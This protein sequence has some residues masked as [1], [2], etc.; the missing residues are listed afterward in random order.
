MLFRLEQ[1]SARFT[2][3]YKK[4]MSEAEHPLLLS[5]RR[6]FRT[7]KHDFQVQLALMSFLRFGDHGVLEA[8]VT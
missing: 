1:N 7:S 2:V 5:G 8:D 3:G 6:A 4:L